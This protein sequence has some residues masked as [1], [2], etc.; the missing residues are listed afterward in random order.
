MKFLNEEV[1]QN[2]EKAERMAWNLNLKSA[3][4]EQEKVNEVKVHREHSRF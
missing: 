3:Y 2:E 4:T 1:F